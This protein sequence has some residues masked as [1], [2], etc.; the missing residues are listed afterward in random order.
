VQRNTNGAAQRTPTKSPVARAPSAG[1][2]KT[3]STE[4]TETPKRRTTK[5]K[6]ITPIRLSD[7]PTKKY[8]E[9]RKGG[10]DSMKDLFRIKND[11]Q[12]LHDV[13]SVK[14][15]LQRSIQLNGDDSASNEYY[16]NQ[17]DMVDYVVNSDFNSL[18]NKSVS[19]SVDKIKSTAD[20]WNPANALQPGTVVQGDAPTV[21]AQDGL[22]AT[23]ALPVPIHRAVHPVGP[24]AVNAVAA[25]PGNAWNAAAAFNPVLDSSPTP[26]SPR[27]VQT[28]AAAAAAAA[29]AVNV[30]HDPNARG[31]LSLQFPLAGVS[32]GMHQ[33]MVPT[34]AP[35]QGVISGTEQFPGMLPNVPLVTDPHEIKKNEAIAS[36]SVLSPT[37][38][39]FQPTPTTAD[40]VA[41]LDMV[42]AINNMKH[43]QFGTAA[44]VAAHVPNV[45]G[46]GQFGPAMAAQNLLG[47]NNANAMNQ[48]TANIQGA[49]W[50]PN[51]L[52]SGAPPHGA[53]QGAQG[54]PPPAM[55][56][57]GFQPHAPGGHHSAAHGGARGG[58]VGAN[59]G[60]LPPR[61]GYGHR[62]GGNRGR[63]Y[64]ERGRG[65]GYGPPRERGGYHHGDGHRESNNWHQPHH[66]QHRGGHSQHNGG[67]HGRRGG[68]YGNRYVPA[69]R[70]PYNGRD[71]GGGGREY[72]SRRG[73][74][75]R[76][77]H[78]GRD[79][80]GSFRGRRQRA[81]YRRI[82][83]KKEQSEHQN[84]LYKEQ[85][86]KATEAV[87]YD[88]KVLPKWAAVESIDHLF[89]AADDGEGS[90][91]YDDGLCHR[92]LCSAASDGVFECL[93]LRECVVSLSTANKELYRRMRASAPV[94]R[95]LTLRGFEVDL[96]GHCVFSIDALKE[97]GGLFGWANGEGVRSLVIKYSEPAVE[98]MQS[99][100]WDPLRVYLERNTKR[101]ESVF[102]GALEPDAAASVS[103]Q[104]QNAAVSSMRRL[105]S[106]M[107]SCPQL[108]VERAP[109]PIDAAFI[110]SMS[111]MT[112]DLVLLD[113]N[114]LNQS[115]KQR[116]ELVRMVR[117]FGCL[118]RFGFVAGCLNMPA[119]VSIVEGSVDA[120]LIRNQRN[121]HR[122]NPQDLA[123]LFDRFES[124]ELDSSLIS[125]Y[126]STRNKV[127]I[128]EL[129]VRADTHNFFIQLLLNTPSS[130]KTLT[131]KNATFS[132]NNLIVDISQKH[133]FN[134]G[135]VQTLVLEGFADDFKQIWTVLRSGV[136]PKL[137][138]LVI[139]FVPS[140][141]SH[142]HHRAKAAQIQRHLNEHR[143]RYGRIRIDTVVKDSVY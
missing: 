69:N 50:V 139:H 31:P 85:I 12:K 87:H 93:G 7:G 140:D 76:P 98:W 84:Q 44:P 21:Y 26:N 125:E 86:F 134:T 24:P 110:S 92:F 141:R 10:I 88:A 5:K 14:S 77:R 67:G 116:E 40:V 17:Q 117:C 19:V 130:V 70:R 48:S 97:R 27:A 126:P 103:D 102:L 53:A 47:F 105:F 82:E 51:G 52:P 136:F 132:S 99:I 128:R 28:A 9:M 16:V 119:L 133:K 22:P 100:P 94:F 46:F 15:E 90:K 6:Q 129:T 41:P 45:G 74:R 75:E 63:A 111:A 118:R 38:N 23:A 60:S 37:V 34:H 49:Q 20:A 43:F 91:L 56:G 13:A 1:E 65:R 106:S 137:R 101:L 64:N 42:G 115:P 25:P 120:L 83:N 58:G 66:Q 62:G 73:E 32:Q 143:E 108:I 4:P 61:G 59:Y 3:S 35:G 72:Q 121:Q 113:S 30:V 123:M 112:A 135:G 80:G 55:D 57:M 107:V 131:I 18:N 39:E 109:F 122:L 71:G 104:S 95:R 114:I 96:D 68:G 36:S 127:K 54:P 79:R 8:L 124:I 11:S 78:D 29:T 89:G 142:K 2:S 138:R 81:G 33:P